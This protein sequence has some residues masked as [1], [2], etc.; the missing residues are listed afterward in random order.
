MVIDLRRVI[1]SS[2][3]FIINRT[4]LKNIICD[5]YPKEKQ[6]MHTLLNIYE[7][8]I[9]KKIKTE[10]QVTDL[11]FDQYVET[12]KND[13]GLQEELVKEGLGAWVD[14]YFDEDSWISKASYDTEPGFIPDN[15]YKIEDNTIRLRLAKTVPEP[16]LSYKKPRDIYKDTSR[17]KPK[18]Q[19]KTGHM[20][21]YAGHD[22]EIIS[23]TPTTA[24]VSRII[25]L[26]GSKITIPH[27]VDGYNVVGIGTAAFQKCERLEELIISEGIEYVGSR[28][29][30][31]CDNLRR[32]EI[33]LS[34][35]KIGA[36]AF[37]WTSL[38]VINLSGQL[39]KIADGSFAYCRKLKKIDFP[40]N[41]KEIG[42]DAFKNCSRL[43]TIF[44]PDSVKII[45]SRAFKYCEQLSKV[46]LNEGL[47]EVGGKAFESCTALRTMV[48]P[49]SVDVFGKEIFGPVLSAPNNTII[50][51]CHSGS[52]AIG[53][54]KSHKIKLQPI[55]SDQ[56]LPRL[57]IKDD[58]ITQRAGDWF[59]YRSITDSTIEISDYRSDIG[60]RIVIPKEVNGRRVVGIGVAAF[61]KCKEL[62]EVVISEGIS[63][64]GRKAFS[65]CENL[66][67]ITFPTTLRKLGAHSFW[68]T[69]LE[70][71]DLPDRIVSIENNAFNWCRKLREIKLPGE[72]KIIE[73]SA[74]YDCNSLERINLPDSVV[75]IGS[76]AFK[77]CQKITSVD[78]N[79]GLKEIGR[80]GFDGCKELRKMEIPSS[81]EVFGEDVFGNQYLPSKLDIV[82]YC[83]PDSKAIEY[84]RMNNID[85]VNVMT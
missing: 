15:G 32:V 63:Y 11:Q 82:L 56:P 43:E 28:A 64:I 22:L 72:L 55:I 12:I 35:K 24:E 46:S 42:R 44:L 54:A 20:V 84:A 80:A 25:H 62:E 18:L 51:E 36:Y 13:Y 9:L 73:N 41:L 45:G 38:E 74:F 78:L 71:V 81:V 79:N 33:P 16:F 69:A 8:G 7:S 1:N 3:D 47:K 23:L 83:A 29:F 77:N 68:G 2:K 6:E 31:Y 27:M 26:N 59:E 21:N 75:K 60:N 30:A 58:S 37:V 49:S 34:L 67:K 10:G 50:L 5:L 40:D 17:K 19:K 39:E 53:Y 57:V 66:S 65:G 4:L 52:K 48:I 61:E 70:V 14:I 76:R 85:A